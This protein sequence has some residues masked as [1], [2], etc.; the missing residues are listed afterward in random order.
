M[1]K[2]LAVWIDHEQARVFHIDPE[3]IEQV[4]VSAPDHHI[5][6]RARDKEPH[7]RKRYLRQVARALEGAEAVLVAGPSRTK[8][9]LFKFLHKHDPKLEKRIV[10]LETVKESSD[11][12]FVRYAQDYFKLSDPM[13]GPVTACNRPPR[14]SASRPWSTGVAP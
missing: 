5:R 11:G 2:H 7:D 12:L 10:G 9:T 13:R 8:Y 14:N 4:T 3:R 1:L 6:D